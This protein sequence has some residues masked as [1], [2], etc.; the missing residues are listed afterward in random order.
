MDA[1][2]WR[3]KNTMQAFSDKLSSDERVLLAQEIGAEGS[4]IR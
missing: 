1:P 4:L 2:Y 3:L